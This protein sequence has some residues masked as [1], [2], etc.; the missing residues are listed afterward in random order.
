MSFRSSF[1]GRTRKR[2]TSW[3]TRLTDTLAQL[4]ITVGGIGTIVAVILVCVFLIWVV[5]PLFERATVTEKPI[6]K[7]PLDGQQPVRE[8]MD[9]YRMMGWSLAPDGTLA[10]FRLDDGRLL[11]HA[12]PVALHKG[13]DLTAWSAPGTAE[14][15]ALGFADGSVQLGRIGFKSRLLEDTEITAELR[16]LKADQLVEFSQ[17]R[18]EFPHGVVQRLSDGQYRLQSLQLEFD[19]PISSGSTKTVRQID[20]SLQTRNDTSRGETTSLIACLSADG[21]LRTVASEKKF[22]EVL[23]DFRIETLRG[24]LRLPDFEDR[25]W[26]RWLLV[27]GGGSNTY[28]LWEG[29]RLLRVATREPEEPRIMEEVDLLAREP[30]CRITAAR[31]LLGKETLLV[32]DSLGRVQAWFRAQRSEARAPD[33]QTLVAGHTFAGP[34]SAVTA[35]A[36]S[37]ASRMMAVGF[38]DGRAR[39]SFVTSEKLIAEVWTQQDEPIRWLLLAPKDDG[40]LAQCGERCWAWR[41]KPLHPEITFHA[42]FRPVWYEGYPRPEYVWQSTGGDAA[43]AKYSLIPLI[44]GTLKATFYSLLLGVPIALLAAIYTSEFLHP[45]TKAILKPSIEMMASLPSV[46]LGFLAALVLAPFVDRLLPAVLAGF[47]TLP[48]AFLLGAYA[49]QLLPEKGSLFLQRF[50]FGFLCLV[51]PLG[52]LAAPA[53]GW[54]LEKLLFAGDVRGW[55]NNQDRGSAL[56]G[57]FLLL[58]PVAAILITFLA[59]HRVNSRLRQVTRDWS[60]LAIALL[61]LAKFGVLSLAVCVLAFLLAGLLTLVG[62][63]P[64]GSF[65]GKYDQ[66]NALVVG[67]MMGFAIIPIIY[68]IAEDALSMVPEHLRSAS[69]GCGAT[70]WQTAMRVIIPTAMSG[71]F[72]AVMVGLGR[73]VGETMIVLMG[74]GN[75]PVLDWNIF[76]GFRT[77]SANIATELPEAVRDSTHYRTLFLAALTLFAM[78]FVLNTVAEMVRLRFRKRAFQL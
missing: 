25:G 42:L 39:L 45:R 61:D 9:E 75:T 77:L 58:L 72:S 35:L 70:P 55:L 23:Q 16:D 41:I 64:R 57:W 74:T 33:R 69:L 54:V 14:H 68:T 51:G 24:E 49:W 28:L 12:T 50:R 26:P 38:A 53:V 65:L 32:G 56:P 30:S 17:K 62:L 2:A 37:S 27:S 52:L 13:A 59:G 47:L 48:G 11:D 36:A 7:V 78:T 21:K 60:R 4:L 44:F 71:L 3:S 1:T 34:G 46:V 8:G 67:F 29:G 20:L 10:T 63:D 76:N 73:A 43:E 5:V 6:L 22:V 66:R 15:I 31:F 40:L 19:E 18:N